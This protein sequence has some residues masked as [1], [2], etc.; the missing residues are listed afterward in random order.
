MKTLMKPSLLSVVLSA[1]LLA[2]A[3][4]AVFAQAAAP[5]TAG[6]QNTASQ[7]GLARNTL[8]PAVKGFRA[9]KRAPVAPNW[10]YLPTRPQ[11]PAGMQERPRAEGPVRA[12]GDYGCLARD[13]Q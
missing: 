11:P 8:P 12:S 10:R 7:G 1:A 2:S 9:E 5:A 6:K 4:V 3:P 13:G